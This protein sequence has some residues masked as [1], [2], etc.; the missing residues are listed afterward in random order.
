MRL[1][2]LVQWLRK[3]SYTDTESDTYKLKL[4]AVILH[5]AGLD[6]IVSHEDMQKYQDVKREVLY[7]LETAWLK[8]NGGLDKELQSWV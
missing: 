8:D 2:E 7:S 4:H 3:T 1:M 6:C 5:R